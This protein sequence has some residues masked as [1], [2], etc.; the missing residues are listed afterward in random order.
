MCSFPFQVVLPCSDIT[1]HNIQQNMLQLLVVPESCLFLSSYCTYF[2]W[3]WHSDV[4]A[5]VMTFLRVCRRFASSEAVKH[6]RVKHSP[7]TEYLLDRTL[8]VD[9]AGELCAVHIYKGQLAVLG[10][11]DVAPTLQV[12]SPNESLTCY[13]PLCY[14]KILVVTCHILFIIII[15][16]VINTDNGIFTAPITS[17]IVDALQCLHSENIISELAK[18]LKRISNKCSIKKYVF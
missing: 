11:S 12:K 10:R 7:K 18:T 5:T 16:I 15:I 2:L 3:S 6:A 8:R 17:K 1:K 13:A 9:H 4:F 14:T